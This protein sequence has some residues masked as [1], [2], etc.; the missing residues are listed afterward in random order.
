MTRKMLYLTTFFLLMLIPP[1]SFTAQTN[2]EPLPDDFPEIT[3]NYANNPSDGWI[4][5]ANFKRGTVDEP[6][7]LDEF[8]FAVDNEGMVQF[9]H[10]VEG[11]RAFN[12]H[13]L[14]DGRLYYFNLT[15]TGVGSGAAMDGDHRFINWA[16]EILE[17]V[18]LPEPAPNNTPHEF[19]LLGNGN[20][21]LL[22]Q[23]TRIMDLTAWGG[24]EDAVV[25]DQSIYEITPE[26]EIVFQWHSPDYIPIE[27][28][29]R[30]QYL[31]TQ[32]PEGVSYIHGNGMTVD[33]DGN[34]ILSVRRFDE[35]I[36]IDRQ[37]GEIIWRM[38]GPT[39]KHNEFTFID[40][41]YNGF[42]G[43]HNPTI[44]PDGH[45]LLFD[46]GDTR[47]E[48]DR[49]SRA[50]EYEINEENRTVTL[51]WQFMDRQGRYTNTMGSAQRLP[52]GNTLIGWGSAPP[53]GPS[54]SEVTA[55]GEVVLALSLPPTQI[56]YRVYRFPAPAD[57]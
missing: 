25:V 21:L 57:D 39:S 17:D 26:G 11:F 32:P 51:V 46:N 36:K 53:N 40:D 20:M 48:E 12:F 37:T 22:S 42:S 34:I 50:V 45:L 55:E 30:P 27:D 35:L 47:P 54:V 49:V 56:N 41:P 24:A 15:D 23:P 33:L 10:R 6:D 52:N 9:Y 38:G 16:G 44:L 2:T 29:A 14:E 43:Q 4:Y 28:T 19:V 7:N 18:R 3:I 8:V 1:V 13:P 31:S 5:L